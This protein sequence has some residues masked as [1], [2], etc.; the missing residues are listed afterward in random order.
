MKNTVGIAIH[1]GHLMTRDWETLIW[2][3][4]PSRLGSLP[5]LAL[6]ILDMFASESAPCLVVFGTG[7]SEKDGLK[8]SEY[9]KKYFLTH[10]D[11]LESFDEIR[12]HPLWS[13]ENLDQIATMGRAVVCET[14]AQNTRE[15]IRAA[16]KLF[17]ALGIQEVL[18]ITCGSHAPRCLQNYLQ[19]RAA[20][21]IPTRQEWRIL[22]DQTVY[23]GSSIGD[24]IVVEPP[25]RSD[26]ILVEAPI[27]LS[28]IV[29][30][31]YAL[32]GNKRLEALTDFQ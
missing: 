25:H 7:A 1:G 12:N 8:E 20:G 27:R 2:G 3:T 9:I 31:F 5:M 29:K 17:D 13:K 14:T 18:H 22:P 30:E 19:L 23:P 26:D 6:T 32:D 21:E 16:A 10:L 24:V 15:E 4:A 28:H 11:D